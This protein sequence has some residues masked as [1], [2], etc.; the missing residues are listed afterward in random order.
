MF[1]LDRIHDCQRYDLRWHWHCLHM[2]TS[3]WGARVYPTHST[4][5]IILT[6]LKVK[7]L[8]ESWVCGGPPSRGASERSSSQLRL[9]ALIIAAATEREGTEPASEPEAVEGDE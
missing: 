4:S 8:Q 1:H 5:G 3:Q 2:V 9:R 6:A 7:Q